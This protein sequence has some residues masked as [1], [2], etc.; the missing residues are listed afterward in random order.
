MAVT[1]AEWAIADIAANEQGLVV[2]ALYSTLTPER[3][4]VC[5]IGA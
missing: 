2:V 4:L 3:L 1:R 5:F